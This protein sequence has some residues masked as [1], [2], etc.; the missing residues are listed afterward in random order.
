[1][2]LLNQVLQDLEKRDAEGASEQNQLSQIKAVSPAYKK[3]PLYLITFLFLI[4]ILAA[5][6][7]FIMDK[8]SSGTVNPEPAPSIAQS[9]K[10]IKKPA[11]DTPILEKKPP[12]SEQI[13][14]KADSQSLPKLQLN[15]PVA[16]HPIKNQTTGNKTQQQPIKNAP[17]RI[18]RKSQT[19]KIKP[20]KQQKRKLAKKLS[21][22]QQ[23]E[24][25][26]ILAKK[27]K[28]SIDQQ[29]KLR[30]TLQLNPKHIEARLILANHLLNKGMTS[31]TETMLDQ[32]LQLLPHN[33]Q[34]ISFRSQLF[35]QNKQPLAALSL[36]HQI[37]SSDSQDE[38]Y[39]SLLASAY[40]QTKDHV[41][42]LQTYQKLLSIN[43]K[44]AEYWLG[45]AIA[46]EKQGNAK[47]ALSAY[48]FALNKK[49]LKSAVVSYINRRVSLLK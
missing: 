43:P 39:L 3:A 6:G 22:Q 25:V 23:A 11:S 29:E 15:K 33:K 12:I 47:Q 27:Q 48:Q 46:L 7:Y 45:L 19:N 35:L 24:K 34:L 20:Y 26:F 49:T 38:M 41:K 32:G 2:S 10:S 9:Q 13:P 14:V 5:A 44:K 4:G 36:L 31:K 21:N 30:Q 40:Q 16:S 18:E 8:P 1:M 17:K 37:N 42:S 28:N